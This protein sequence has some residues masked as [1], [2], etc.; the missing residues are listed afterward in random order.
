MSVTETVIHAADQ[1]VKYVLVDITSKENFRRSDCVCSH[2]RLPC[3]SL[4]ATLPPDLKMF[5]EIKGGNVFCAHS[6]KT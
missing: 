1:V 3:P 4:P 6:K 5:K 2:F